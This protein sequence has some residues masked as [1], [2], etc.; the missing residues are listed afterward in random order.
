[1]K[2]IYK[3][4]FLFI[5][6][7]L[8]L[9]LIFFQYKVYN[10]IKIANERIFKLEQLDPSYQKDKKLNLL[11]IEKIYLTELSKIRINNYNYEFKN[12]SSTKKRC[13]SYVTFIKINY[14]ISGDG[15]IKDLNIVATTKMKINLIKP[16]QK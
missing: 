7:F 14:F 3:N 4:V 2:T 11:E 9:F 8:I 1:M 16:Y 5:L 12:F 13:F 10:R 6:L 15:N